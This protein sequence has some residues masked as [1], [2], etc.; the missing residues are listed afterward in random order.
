MNFSFLNWFGHPVIIFFI[1][2]I[3]Y[4]HLNFLVTFFSFYLT[5]FF[6]FFFCFYQIAQWHK[7]LFFFYS[8]AKVSSFVFIFLLLALLQLFQEGTMK[9]SFKPHLIASWNWSLNPYICHSFKENRITPFL[10]LLLFVFTLEPTF[11]NVR[12]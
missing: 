12:I 8:W 3:S 2:S 7:S 6:L 11:Y 4:F 1:L 5:L 9:I 10:S